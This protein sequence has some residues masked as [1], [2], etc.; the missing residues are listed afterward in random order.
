MSIQ[1]M[2]GV[3]CLVVFL[4]AGSS[5]AEIRF[6]RH[7]IDDDGPDGE[8]FSNTVLGDLDK[9]GHVDVIVGRST[10]GQGPKTIYWYRNL[11]RIDAWSGPWAL[12]SNAD[13]GC[14][15]VL[16]DVDRD[17][18][19]DLVEG[20]WYRNPGHPENGAEFAKRGGFRGGHD[21]EAPDLDGDGRPEIVV[22][23]QF[24]QPGVYVSK[25]P[26]H[27]SQPWQSIRALEVRGRQLTGTP[28]PQPS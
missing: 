25:A 6:K 2:F 9:D 3:F 16:L 28:P 1:R 23:S 18:W 15:G 13:C 22:H 27:P 24:D 17:G 11:G 26:Q 21:T 4:T 8:V 12:C 20:G 19:P 10:Y 7:F 5:D 14:G